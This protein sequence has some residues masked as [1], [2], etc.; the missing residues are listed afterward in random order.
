MLLFSVVKF[1]SP[2]LGNKLAF[3]YVDL[4]NFLYTCKIRV[5]MIYMYVYL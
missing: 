2:V 1:G 4:D 3:F 5:K